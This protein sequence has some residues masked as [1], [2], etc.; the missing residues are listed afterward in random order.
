MGVQS[1]RFRSVT[2]QSED[3]IRFFREGSGL[4]TGLSVS[5]QSPLPGT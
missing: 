5:F 2:A 1:I 4:P 3:L